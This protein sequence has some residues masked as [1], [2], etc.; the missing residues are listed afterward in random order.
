MERVQE[1]QQA[2]LLSAEV[3]DDDFDDKGSTVASTAA[4]TDD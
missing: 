3:G 2:G 4:S 1:L